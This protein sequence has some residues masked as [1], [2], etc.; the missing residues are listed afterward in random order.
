MAKTFE[1]DPVNGS[2]HVFEDDANGNLLITQMQDVQPALDWAKK[3]RNSGANDLGGAKDKGDAKHYATVSQGAI[4]RM[5]DEGIDFWN[6]NDEK[7]ML[8]WIE[9]EAPRCKV[10]NRKIL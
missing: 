10:T 9:R 4:I 1:V 6:P 3:Q 5:R 8:K 2:Y 7:R